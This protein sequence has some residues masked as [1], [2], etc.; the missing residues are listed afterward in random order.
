MDRPDGAGAIV[1]SLKIR[2]MPSH[3]LIP[4]AASQTPGCEQA[5][6]HL[7]LPQLDR[8]LA[9]LTLSHTDTGQEADFAPPHERALARALGLPEPAT[10]WAAAA[11][12][13]AGEGWAYL[14]P[15]HWQVG[16]DHVTLLHPAQLQLTEADSRT[17]VDLLAPWLAQDGITLSYE[18]STRWL[19]R[20]DLFKDLESASLDRVIDRDVRAWMPRGPRA[21]E[22]QRL[23]SE[24]QMLLY[25]H[26]FS[27][28]RAAAGQLAVNAFWVHGA[29]QL[30]TLPAPRDAPEM[31]GALFDAA[32]QQDWSAWARAW[33]QLDSGPVAELLRQALADNRVTLTLCGEA[34]AL[35]F[36]SQ[37]RGLGAKIH[38]LFGRQRFADLRKQL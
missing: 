32:L 6:S 24:V 5:L 14:T 22:V 27:E 16:A 34:S 11:Q 37:Q 33:Q 1:A 19:A 31:P 4:L 12:H 35:S 29:G 17:L 38:S 30:A 10:P 23:H 21:T 8:L 28:A 9:R 25:T 18:Q 15:C 2:A 36:T 3:L 13:T 26:A 20:G 7:K